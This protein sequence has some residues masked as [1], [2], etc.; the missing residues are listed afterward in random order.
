[1]GMIFPTLPEASFRYRIFDSS[2]NCL[3][4]STVKSQV[5]NLGF[6]YRVI[7]Q[8]TAFAMDRKWATTCWSFNG[9]YPGITVR[10]PLTPSF[11]VS[12]ASWTAPCVEVLQT[13][14]TTGTRPAVDFTTTSM[15]RRFV[16]Q[17]K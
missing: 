1:M 8:E 6:V 9:K 10:I 4:A 17:L 13:P 14:A 5:W 12:A 16:S 3:S 11:S 15:V 2:V 7:G